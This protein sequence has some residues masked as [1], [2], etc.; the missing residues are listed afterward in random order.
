MD[1]NDER[2]LKGFNSGYILAKHTPEIY[3]VI[4]NGIEPKSD[5]LEGFVSG[6]KQYEMEKH[7]PTK[8]H[9]KEISKDKIKDRDIE[10]D[11]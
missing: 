10:H 6:G 1:N 5:Y 4:E 3:A 11:R 9:N 8:H 2:Y 7:S